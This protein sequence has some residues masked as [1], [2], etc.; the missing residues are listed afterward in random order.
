MRLCWS[1]R[2]C[3]PGLYSIAE[4]LHDESI[5]EEEPEEDLDPDLDSDDDFRT[6]IEVP[7]ISRVNSKD[8][9]ATAAEW[10]EKNFATIDELQT[11]AST[12]IPREDW[13]GPCVSSSAPGFARLDSP[14]DLLS[15]RVI[16]HVP[17][18]E[19]RWLA[20]RSHELYEELGARRAGQNY[21][22]VWLNCGMVSIVFLSDMTEGS[23]AAFA[24]P[25]ILKDRLKL[26]MNAVQV[27]LPIP[28]AGPRGAATVANFFGANGSSASL[29]R[30]ALGANVA[31]LQIDLYSKWIMR[32]ALQQGGF[33]TGNT[34]ELY[35]VDWPGQAVVAGI[36][37]MMTENFLRQIA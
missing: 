32:M 31:C 25:R 13:F 17:G 22:A 3:R 16:K 33:R 7:D 19:K 12:P 14:A 35:M 34:I 9:F 29:V 18:E 10:I 26:V 23:A 21:V 37:L 15:A 24:D 5:S 1:F 6:A 20:G 30:T 27:R 36:R 2:C 4:D 11:E 8:S 28:S